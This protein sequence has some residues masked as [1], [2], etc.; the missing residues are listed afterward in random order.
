MAFASPPTR[1]TTAE[2]ARIFVTTASTMSL[3]L[4]TLLFQAEQGEADIVDS[5]IEYLILGSVDVDLIVLV[6]SGGKI[7]HHNLDDCV[8]A[9]EGRLRSRIAEDG[10]DFILHIAW[11]MDVGHRI[12]KV[13]FE[14]IRK[15]F[16]QDVVDESQKG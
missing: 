12:P 8:R 7:S 10:G 15:S 6:G 13:V 11:L 1:A 4:T 9:G 3:G 14:G 5:Q 2:M 16:R